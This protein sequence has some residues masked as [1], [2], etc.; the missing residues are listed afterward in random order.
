[1]E[2][3]EGFDVFA[4]WSHKGFKHRWSKLQDGEFMCVVARVSYPG[5]VAQYSEPIILP[6]NTD[7]TTWMSSRVRKYI[8]WR[9][10][11]EVATNL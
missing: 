5:I 7:L 8:S 3:F 1:M 11:S 2:G 9:L 10:A 6:V 4:E